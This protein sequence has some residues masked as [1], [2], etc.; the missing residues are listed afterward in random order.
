MK[1]IQL[2]ISLLTIFITGPIWYY[3]LFKILQLVHATDVM[4]LL[5]WVYLPLGLFMEIMGVIIKRVIGD[6]S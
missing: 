3:L 5:F 2:M 1:A 6:E 4:W